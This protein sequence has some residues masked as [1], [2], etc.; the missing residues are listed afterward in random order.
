MPPPSVRIDSWNVQFEESY[1][2]DNLYF[3]DF[4]SKWTVIDKS[5]PF[6]LE[7]DQQFAERKIEVVQFFN[8]VISEK[9]SKNLLPRAD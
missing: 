4:Q 9:N 7:I 2:K 5:E 8:S 6:S 1:S 3:R